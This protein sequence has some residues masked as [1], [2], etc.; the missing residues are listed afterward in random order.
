[1]FERAE[2]FAA[3]G[4]ASA[5]VKNVVNAKTADADEGFTKAVE[6]SS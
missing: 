4:Q 2:F 6:N 3:T 1:V 5:E